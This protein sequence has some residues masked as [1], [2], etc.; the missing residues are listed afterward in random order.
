MKNKIKK[1][2]MIVISELTFEK[3]NAKITK[4]V[5]AALRKVLNEKI[6]LTQEPLR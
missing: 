1:Q 6:W 4:D 2:Y 3:T 5:G